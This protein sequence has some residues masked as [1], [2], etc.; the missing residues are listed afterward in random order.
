MNDIKWPKVVP[1][2]LSDEALETEVIGL[3][4]S[5]SIAQKVG[6]MI[7]PDIRY[8]TPAEAAEFHIG[9]VLSG[10]RAWATG[11]PWLTTFTMRCLRIT[12]LP[13]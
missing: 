5:M 6:Q 9:S 8:I 7:Q 13:R 3:L 11:W 1:A 4:D 2:S 10:E 12:L